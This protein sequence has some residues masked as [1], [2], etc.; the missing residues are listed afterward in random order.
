MTALRQKLLRDLRLLWT[1]AAAISLVVACGVATF[2]M[3]VSVLQ[4]LERRAAQYYED[5]RLPHVFAHLKRAPVSIARRVA[6][7]PGIAAVET[8]VVAEVTLDLP[9]VIEPAVGRLVSIPDHGEP[10]LSRQP[11]PPSSSAQ[12]SPAPPPRVHSRSAGS[13]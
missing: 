10:S 13:P 4:S 11:H 1:Q 2:V 6:E 8:R 5:A 3:S 7:V 9:G 12:V